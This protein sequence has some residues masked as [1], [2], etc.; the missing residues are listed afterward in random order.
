MVL[1]FFQ[2]P[3]EISLVTAKF[4]DPSFK[5]MVYITRNEQSVVT[6]FSK[7]MQFSAYGIYLSGRSAAEHNFNYTCHPRPHSLTSCHLIRVVVR[8]L[9]DLAAPKPAFAFLSL[10]ELTGTWI[11][12]QSYLIN[13]K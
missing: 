7:L 13:I 10:R 3:G 12:E 11:S 6:F 4:Q 1:L 8:V 9:L 2:R 5:S